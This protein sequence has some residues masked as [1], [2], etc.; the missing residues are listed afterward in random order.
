VSSMPELGV[1][2][3]E[4][5]TMSRPFLVPTPIER[6]LVELV[7]T[8]VV[9]WRAVEREA[10][11]S[12]ADYVPGVAQVRR[13]LELLRGDITRLQRGQAADSRRWVRL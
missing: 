10:R 2:S 11:R 9:W 5:P 3:P 13:A 7:E 1:M 8:A 6:Q 4:P 12:A